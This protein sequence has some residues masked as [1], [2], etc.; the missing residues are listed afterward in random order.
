MAEISLRAGEALRIDGFDGLSVR[1]RSN[2][3][4]LEIQFINPW[5][6]RWLRVWRE[7]A[8]TRVLAELDEHILRDIGMHPGSSHPLATR[9]HALRQQELRRIAIARFG[10]V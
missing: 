3:N 6:K 1:L 7:A 10:L 9:L 8:Q 2:G 4:G 5:W